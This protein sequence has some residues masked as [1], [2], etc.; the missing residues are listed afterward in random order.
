[1]WRDVLA[2]E[3]QQVLA[4]LLGQ[5][6]AQVVG[7]GQMIGGDDDDGV[8]AIPAAADACDEFADQ[9]VAAFDCM[10]QTDIAQCAVVL[11]ALA[12]QWQV[13]GRMVGVHGQRGQH[14]GLAGT[15]Q[16]L[17]GIPG[18]VQQ[19]IVVHAPCR[20]MLPD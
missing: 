4:F 7:H 18:V 9:T 10:Q 16:R 19:D 8:F 14:E 11:L 12:R 1:M 2:Q 3:Q 6:V 13:A 20:K 17:E 15:R 5:H